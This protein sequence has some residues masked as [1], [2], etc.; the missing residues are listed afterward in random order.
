MIPIQQESF[1]NWDM[2]IRESLQVEPHVVLSPYLLQ[3]IL[4]YKQL[5]SIYFLQVHRKVMTG[6]K[7]RITHLKT[8]S[9]YVNI[10]QSVQAGDSEQLT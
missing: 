6:M 5:V 7:R 1:R 3:M 4:E 8:S 2:H 10:V 9:M